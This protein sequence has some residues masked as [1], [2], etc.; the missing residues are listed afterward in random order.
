MIKTGRTKIER[1]GG[2]VMLSVSSSR[3]TEVSSR[4]LRLNML[5]IG[6]GFGTVSFRKATPDI[7][8]MKSKIEETAQGRK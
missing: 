4:G 8:E 7:Q 6:N 2:L 5:E 1:N 3:I